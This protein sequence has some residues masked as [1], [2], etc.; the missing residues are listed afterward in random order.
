VTDPL[1]H[2]R[3]CFLPNCRECLEAAAWERDFRMESR[4][5]TVEFWYACRSY[6]NELAAHA[7]RRDDRKEHQEAVAALL[8]YESLIRLL[9]G[10]DLSPEGKKRR[11]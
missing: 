7:Y 11:G 5:L 8:H 4:R 10:K 1:L 2:L 6:Y 3:S 9:T